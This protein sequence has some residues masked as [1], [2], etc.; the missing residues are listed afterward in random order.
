MLFI[1]LVHDINFTHDFLILE[2]V[3][4]DWTKTDPSHKFSHIENLF[5]EKIN[6]KKWTVLFFFWCDGLFCSLQICLRK[7]DTETM[8]V[9]PSSTLSLL[10]YSFHF[11]FFS[12]CN[13]QIL[14][15]PVGLFDNYQVGERSEMFLPAN[16]FRYL[17]NVVSPSK[18]DLLLFFYQI[19][20][21]FFSISCNFH[22]LLILSRKGR[23]I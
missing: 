10:L 20:I 9:S 21:F 11:F 14:N 13:S 19:Y 16:N 5:F 15:V 8:W 6:Q 22:L 3:N 23:R 7:C 18:P 12:K 1:N 4:A 17:N 2:F